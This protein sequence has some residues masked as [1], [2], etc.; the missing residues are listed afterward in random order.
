MTATT[1]NTVSVSITNDGY[2]LVN[3]LPE[4]TNPNDFITEMCNDN[5]PD[6][7]K[8]VKALVKALQLGD[9]MILLGISWATEESIRNH[10]RF[11]HIFGVD[12]THGTNNKRRPHL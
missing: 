4:G 11:P 7:A 3:G 1:D 9:N 10:T 2:I 8:C 6:A 12:V 5:E